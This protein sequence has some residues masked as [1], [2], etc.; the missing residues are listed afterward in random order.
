MHWVLE[1]REYWYIYI[2]DN[3]NWLTAGGKWYPHHFASPVLKHKPLV[4]CFS[5]MFQLGY[6]CLLIILF[7][8]TVSTWLYL[9][10]DYF[11][12]EM[13]NLSNCSSVWLWV[14][15]CLFVLM[16]CVSPTWVGI[17]DISQIHP[18]PCLG[19]F[20]LFLLPLMTIGHKAGRYCHFL[21]YCTV[22]IVIRAERRSKKK[23]KKKWRRKGEFWNLLGKGWCLQLEGAQDGGQN[24]I[25]GELVSVPDCVGRRCCF[26]SLCRS[27]SIGIWGC[28]GCFMYTLLQVF[29]WQ[30]QGDDAGTG[31]RAGRW[32][33]GWSA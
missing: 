33:P 22:L 25:W 24:C 20:V 17:K 1:S 8:L 12:H 32:T 28:S 11:S 29:L 2:S 9:S 21:G 26:C 18:V 15:E 6:V 19:V 23:K 7:L 27:W 5:W 3:N 30:E 4:L 14:Y 10:W 13:S 31:Q 16:T